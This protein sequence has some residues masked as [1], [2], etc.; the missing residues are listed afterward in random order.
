MTQRELLFHL[1][2]LVILLVLGAIRLWYYRE[3]RRALALKKQETLNDLRQIAAMIACLVIVTHIIN[4]DLLS[5]TEFA[6]PEWTRWVGVALASL[7]VGASWVAARDEIFVYRQTV[8][9]TFDPPGSFRLVRHPLEL[10][11]V[12][13][14]M[15]LTLLSANWLVALIG[16]TWATHE[17]VVR[18]PRVERERHARMG[19]AY[20]AYARVTP[21]FVPGFS[22]SFSRDTRRDE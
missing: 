17:V 22:R 2:F 12:S 3:Q 16:G 11:L 1:L 8:S 7:A 15:G 19:E 21:S 20:T 9:K 14:A 13:V 4:P 6:L 10:A 5:W 18:A